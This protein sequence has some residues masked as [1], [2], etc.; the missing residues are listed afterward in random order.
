MFH[1]IFAMPN[2]R[3][4]GE[5]GEE[6]HKAGILEKKQ[7]VFDDF[8]SAAEY[9]LEQKYTNR[10]KLAIIGASN[11]G[12]LTSACVT[13][14][15]DLFGSVIVL[16][17]VI[18]MLRYHRYTIGYFWVPEYGDPANPDHF[19]FLIKYSPLHNIKQGETYPP[20]F[21]KV[22]D[23]DDRVV[24]A[25][26]KKFVATLQAL[27]KGE[28]PILLSIETKAG[29]GLGKPITKQIEEYS[30]IFNFLCK[31]LDFNPYA[32]KKK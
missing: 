5:Y 23:T 18:D 22:A 6:W 25:H 19:K 3:G 7:N 17:A 28:N 2:L 10:K 26:G 14:R 13:Q 30:E 32:E 11:G 1:G 12:L 31:T 24:P 29:H 20:I 21:V 27:D 9:L 16:N 8:I 4:G 15:P